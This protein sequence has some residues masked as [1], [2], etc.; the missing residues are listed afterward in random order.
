[1]VGANNCPRYDACTPR[2]YSNEFRFLGFF[3]LAALSFAG[4]GFDPF[5]RRFIEEYAKAIVKISTK[6]AIVRLCDV[7]AIRNCIAHIPSH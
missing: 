4:S 5:P 6:L 3:S 1:M 2:R 7:I